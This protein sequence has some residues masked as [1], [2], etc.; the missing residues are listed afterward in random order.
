MISYLLKGSSQRFASESLSLS[1]EEGSWWWWRQRLWMRTGRMP[2]LTS[3]WE[4]C[5]V[6]LQ[7]RD[8]GGHTGGTEMRACRSWQV[9]MSWPVSSLT[10]IKF[11]LHW[12]CL[13]SLCICDNTPLEHQGDF[14]PA[15]H[16]LLSAQPEQRPQ[17]FDCCYI[18]RWL[19]SILHP[20]MEKKH[21]SYHFTSS[22]VPEVSPLCFVPSPESITNEWGW[23]R[24]KGGMGLEQWAQEKVIIL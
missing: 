17:S 16:T 15:P 24:K 5:M 9:A 12:A 22:T 11:Y 19:L 3:S 10:K 18:N 13:L 20:P 1:E 6:A 14:P 8:W 7:T 21:M 2:H 4:A 23:G